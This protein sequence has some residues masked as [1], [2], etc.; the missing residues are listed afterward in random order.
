MFLGDLV[1]SEISAAEEM[2]F[3]CIRKMLGQKEAGE[4]DLDK[5]RPVLAKMLNIHELMQSLWKRQGGNPGLGETE[6][7]TGNSSA[8]GLPLRGFPKK[9]LFIVVL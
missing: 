7:C 2:D 5:C 9:N 8:V 6:M 3:S 1:S 4:K